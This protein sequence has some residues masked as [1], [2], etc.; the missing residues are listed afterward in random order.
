MRQRWWNDQSWWLFK[1]D[2]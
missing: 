2:G 1:G